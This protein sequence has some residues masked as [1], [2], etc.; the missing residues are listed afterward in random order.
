[1]KFPLRRY[2]VVFGT[3][4]A[5]SGAAMAQDISVAVVGPMTGSEALRPA[6]QE[7]R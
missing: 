6:V 3:S 4:L 2:F 7:R 5:L 1:M